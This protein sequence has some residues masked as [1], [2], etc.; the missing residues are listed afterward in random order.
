MKS[1]FLASAIVVAGLV[2]TAQASIII[3]PTGA[4]SPTEWVAANRLAVDAVN[5]NGLSSPLV[6]GDAV[7]ATYPTHNTNAGDM[8][9]TSVDLVQTPGQTITFTL[10]QAYNITGIHMWNYNENGGSG[11]LPGRGVEVLDVAFSSDGGT[12]FGAETRFDN[13]PAASAAATDA[14]FDLNYVANNVNAVRFTLIEG[15]SDN[16]FVGIAEVRFI[17]TVVPEPAS[18]GLLAIGA[19]Q[20]LPRSRRTSR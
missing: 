1:A 4:T 17:G 5:G 20:V 3:Q 14:G 9:Q 12:T 10:D 11:P 2:G 19:M 6:T 7:P 8:F 15:I 18:L 13:L 16:R